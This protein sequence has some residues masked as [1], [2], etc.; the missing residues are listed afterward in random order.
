MLKGVTE[1]IFQLAVFSD[2]GHTVRTVGLDA[3]DDIALRRGPLRRLAGVGDVVQTLFIHSDH[4]VSIID[5]WTFRCRHLHVDGLLG[6]A[7]A[8]GIRNLEGKAV[9]AACIRIRLVA[10]RTVGIHRQRAVVAFHRHTA[11][12]H[13]IVHRYGL[14]VLRR[15]DGEALVCSIIRPE[16]VAD[17]TRHRIRFRTGLY[18]TDLIRHSQRRYVVLSHHRNHSTACRSVGIRYS[19]D[20]VMSNGFVRCRVLFVFLRGIRK[21]IGIVQTSG[22][23]V[24]ACHFQISFISRNRSSGESAVF[25]HCHTPDGDATHT[26]GSI[27]IHEAVCRKR[28]LI[29]IRATCKVGLLHSEHVTLRDY[30]GGRI[31]VRVVRVVYNRRIVNAARIA[32]G[33]GHAI[34]NIHIIPT[35][36]STI[37]F[38]IHITAGPADIQTSQPIQTIEES[39]ICKVMKPI[40][41]PLRYNSGRPSSRHKVRLVHGHEKILAGNFSSIHGE[42]RHILT[43]IRGVE[44]LKLEG[45]TVLKGNDKI[46]AITGQHGFI[47]GKVKNKPGFSCAYNSL[48]SSGNRLGKSYVSHGNLLKSIRK[49]KERGENSKQKSPVPVITPVQG[50]LRR[51]NRRRSYKKRERE[52]ERENIKNPAKSVGYL[53]K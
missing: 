21:M 17:L 23:R 29:R 49:R 20:K 7:V 40:T 31:V 27:N 35:R 36:S 43:G 9:L 50:L 6:R 47:G 37:G 34:V 2:R 13:R 28:S 42:R 8:V 39:S 12:A 53:Q 5:D 38:G 30:T 18:F 52:R 19:H 3:V 25:K 24:E 44:V 45:T 48:R 14:A 22:S 4:A 10:V 26:I 46:I 41:I 1:R 32:R 33:N 15:R 16:V 11:A 51:R